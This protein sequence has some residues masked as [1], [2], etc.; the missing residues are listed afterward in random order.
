MI[1]LRFL[2]FLADGIMEYFSLCY[3]I[4]KVTNVGICFVRNIKNYKMNDL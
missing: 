1:K 2:K 3:K 4:I